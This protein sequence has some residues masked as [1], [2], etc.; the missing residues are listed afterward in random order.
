VDFPTE[1]KSPAEPEVEP[2]E[3]VYSDAEVSLLCTPRPRAKVRDESARYGWRWEGVDWRVTLAC[4]IAADTGR[5]IGSIRFLRTAHVTVQPGRMW[6]TF[7]GKSDK[8]RSRGRVPVTDTT[9]ELVLAALERQEVQAA[10]WLLPGGHEDTTHGAHTPWGGFD[11]TGSGKP[12]E[13][14]HKAE[15]L[16]SI[17]RVLGRGYHGVKKAHVSVSYE[18][19]GGDESKVQDLTGNSSVGVLRKHYRRP[20]REGTEQHQNNIR[21]RF[22]EGGHTEAIPAISGNA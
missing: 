8:G 11:V 2:E 20:S 18:L 13:K 22:S 9:A 17:P 15:D 5:R 19:A 6:L 1:R 7:V 3:L 10:G 12:I 14:L 16:L 4:N 21:A